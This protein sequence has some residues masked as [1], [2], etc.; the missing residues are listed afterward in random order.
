[1]QTRCQECA[2]LQLA[3]GE[4]GGEVGHCG[5]VHALLWILKHL[6]KALASCCIPDWDLLGWGIDGGGV[7][8]RAYPGQ[9][10]CTSLFHPGS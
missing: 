7:V 8:C 4:D 6:E 5:G 9:E 10:F 2:E 1:M 3:G